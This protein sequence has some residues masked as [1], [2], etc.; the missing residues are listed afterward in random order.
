MV[1]VLQGNYLT[2]KFRWSTNAT[3]LGPPVKQPLCVCFTTRASGVT[4]GIAILSAL[5]A[6]ERWSIATLW[7]VKKVFFSGRCC[8][9]T[10]MI[11]VP[12]DVLKHYFGIFVKLGL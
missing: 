10:V 11:P 5:R 4:T 3:A 7:R 2:T 6:C 12:L 9:E 1:S 8:I